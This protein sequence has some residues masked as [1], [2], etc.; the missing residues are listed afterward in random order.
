[1]ANHEHTYRA[2]LIWDG[3]RG[4]GT[5]NYKT[6][7]REYRVLM[8]GKPELRG[9][10][11]PTFRGDATVHNPEDLFVA[12]ISGCHMLTYLAL[13]ALAGINVVGY[14]D[15]AKGTMVTDSTGGGRMTEVRLHPVVT[16]ANAADAERALAL[17]EEA[18]AQCF[19][20]N[21]VSVPIHHDA[22]VR[23]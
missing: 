6:Y 10:A 8:D 7:G 18:H 22:E 16:L 20:A 13:C 9:S 15:D 14:R 3:N 11:D 1:M 17:H 19:I 2:Q 12:A 4:D 23:T 21:S 5:T